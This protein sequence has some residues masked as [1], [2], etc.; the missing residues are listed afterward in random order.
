MSSPSHYDYNKNKGKGNQAVGALGIV[1]FFFGIILMIASIFIGQVAVN[2]SGF[3]TLFIS[4]C[5]LFVVG[6]TINMG[7][8]KTRKTS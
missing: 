1:L 4:G 5:I 3:F 8:F 2:M 6:S 7:V